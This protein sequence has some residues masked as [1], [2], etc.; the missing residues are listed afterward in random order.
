MSPGNGWTARAAL[1]F[2]TNSRDIYG[3]LVAWLE[4]GDLGRG[5]SRMCL[6]VG[7][8]VDLGGSPQGFHAF[9]PCSLLSTHRLAQA[10][11]TAAASKRAKAEAAEPLDDKAQVSQHLTSLTFEEWGSRV[12]LRM[13]GAARNFWSFIIYHS[14]QS[15]HWG[16]R[17]KFAL[18]GYAT[19][20]SHFVSLSSGKYKM[21][22]KSSLRTLLALKFDDEQNYSLTTSGG[23]MYRNYWRKFRMV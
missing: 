11:H 1:L 7:Q 18:A 13:G 20:S 3:L 9:V 6:A 21:W 2:W 23:K 19:L 4:L 14:K 22:I 10:F 16:S 17:V 8:L 5:V 12:I 15:H